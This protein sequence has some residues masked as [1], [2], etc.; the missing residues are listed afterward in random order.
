[1]KKKADWQPLFFEFVETNYQKPFSWGKWDCCKF[2][3]ACIKAITGKSLI[4]KELKWKDEESAMKAIKS[5]GGSLGKAIDKAAKAQSLTKVGKVF[6]QCGD[7]V[8]WKEE[9]EMCGMYD[10]QAIL[11]PSDDGIALKPTDLALHGWRIDG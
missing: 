6:L 8:I 2:S 7:L 11:C 1:M 9:S 5:Y 3:D 10:G 4:P